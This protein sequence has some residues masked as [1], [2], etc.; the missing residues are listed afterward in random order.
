MRR[1]GRVVRGVGALLALT[2]LVGAIPWA[3]WHFIG[4]PLPHHVPSAA[5]VGRALDRRGIPAQALVDAL[6]VVVWLAWVSLVASLAVEIPAA[7]S[8]RRARRLP[9]AGVF[10]PLTGRLVAAVVVA[11]LAVAPRPGHLGTPTRGGGLATAVGRRP[12]AALVLTEAT[13][14]AATGIAASGAAAPSTPPAGPPGLTSAPAP[15]VLVPYVVQR[16]DT[17]WGI[18][19][20]KLG[21]PLRWSEIYALNEGRPQP[22]GATLTDPHWIDPGWTLLLPSSTPQP[23]PPPP[24]PAAPGP[25]PTPPASPQAPATISPPPATP[26]E[27]RG[28]HLAVPSTA[29]AHGVETPLQL[30]SGA[31]IAGS[32]AAGVLSALTAQRLRRRR[33][34]RPSPPRPGV[35]LAA[36]AG[37][38]GLRDLQAAV[39]AARG[40]DERDLDA[41]APP[42]PA[43]LSVIPEE[44]AIAHP[45]L[46]A[47]AHRDGAEAHLALSDWPGLRLRGPGAEGALRAWIAALVTRDGPYAAEILIPVE[48]GERLLPGVEL[49]S[50]RRLDGVERLLTRL[51]AAAIGRTR[52][53]EDAALADAAAY[54]RRCPED[55]F[56]LLLAVVGDLPAGA[57]ARWSALMATATRL[58]F[59]ALVLGSAEEDAPSGTGQPGIVIRADGTVG[60][61]A[62]A[63]LGELLAGATLFQL[64]AATAADLLGPVAAVHNDTAV[65]DDTEPV[66]PEG[67]ERRARL[68]SR[69]YRTTTPP[70]PLPPTATT[71][72]PPCPA[73]PSPVGRAARRSRP[74]RQASGSTC[75]DLH[76]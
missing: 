24:N 68:Q 2:A 14:S 50:V 3:L 1:V 53:L 16:G 8:G 60:D 43:P 64:D 40:A 71:P 32:F 6:A 4:W 48:L 74:R 31:V 9:V 66:S 22:G 76:G 61:I 12:V 63:G 39:G 28:A 19:E 70:G 37:P 65:H 10:Q 34:Y 26:V 38:K 17:L 47:V 52:R 23:A 36:P 73:R 57:E 21:D 33:A 30:P 5:Q 42:A 11:G 59:A 55:P 35:R 25:S 54:R 20:R 51:E 29:G 7:V 67:P 45:D 44:A 46:L 18:A 13:S 62:P 49:P 75:S 69:P 58:G 56:P 72:S 15:G 41:P 27:P